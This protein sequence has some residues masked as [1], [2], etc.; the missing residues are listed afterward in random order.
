MA[1]NADKKRHECYSRKAR[2]IGKGAPPAVLLPEGQDFC[3]KPA[4]SRQYIGK[5]AWA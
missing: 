3:G 4:P 2:K 1:V 5:A